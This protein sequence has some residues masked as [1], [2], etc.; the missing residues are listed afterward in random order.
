MHATKLQVWNVVIDAVILNLG[1]RRSERSASHSDRFTSEEKS[2]RHSF[3]WRMF[4]HESRTGP[5]FII[6]IST[7]VTAIALK[8]TVV[9][10]VTPR[11]LVDMY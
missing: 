5:F 4:G 2:A 10:D 9:S 11:S 8:I 1:T 3:T 6:I 7:A